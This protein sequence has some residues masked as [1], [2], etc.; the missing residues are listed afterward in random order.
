MSSLVYKDAGGHEG[1]VMLDPQQ[2]TVLGRDA[3]CEVILMHPSISRRHAVERPLTRRA[4]G[5][6]PRF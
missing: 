2:Q 4:D 3:A 5:V 6:A 1:R